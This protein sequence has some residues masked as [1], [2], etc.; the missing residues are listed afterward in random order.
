MLN[1]E[2][3]MQNYECRIMNAELWMQNDEIKD[4]LHRMQSISAKSMQNV[5]GDGCGIKQLVEAQGASALDS[6]GSAWD[7][8]DLLLRVYVFENL[9]IVTNSPQGHDDLTETKSQCHNGFR[10]KNIRKICLC[11]GK[12]TYFC[13]NSG[14]MVKKVCL[15]RIYVLWYYVV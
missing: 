5:G 7:F 14:K 10:K 2:L 9:Q 11:I 8:R 13:E 6:A 3:W 1:A 4:W 15:I 12:K